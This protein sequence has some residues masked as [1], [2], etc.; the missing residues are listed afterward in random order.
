MIIKEIDLSEQQAQEI[1]ML[2]T[3]L[4][5]IKS[6]IKDFTPQDNKFV[7]EKLIQELTNAQINYDAWFE[8]MQKENNIITTSENSWN[9]DFDKKKLQLIK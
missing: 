4:L 7:F 9:V 5:A 8:K 3:G 1:R 6:L 2:N